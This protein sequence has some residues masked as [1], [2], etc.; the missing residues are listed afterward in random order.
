[1][2]KQVVNRNNVVAG[3]F[4]VGSVLLAVAISFLLS[5]ISGKF[6]KKSEYV[7][8][9]STDV[10]VTGLEAGAEI[11][12]GGLH[13]GR[14]EGITAHK[15]ADPV[16]GIEVI[17]A[18]DV[19]VALV[20]DLVLHE[21]A[22]ADLMLPMLGGLSTINI[23]SAGTGSYVGGPED[24]NGLMD[25]GE[26]MR[27]RF[28]PSILTQ[29]GF[30][31]EEAEKIKASIDDVK[32]I[33]G[34]ARESTA[35]VRRMTDALEPEFIS[36]VDDGKSTI[37]NVRAF[38]EQLN[39]E[40]GWS[41]RVDGIL[42]KAE[43]ASAKLEPT[44]DE[45]RATLVDARAVIAESKPKV[46]E[47]LDNVTETTEQFKLESLAKMDALIEKGSLALGSYKDLADDARLIVSESRPK[48]DSTLD[49][50]RDIGVNSKMMIEELR[51]QPWRLLK[52]PTKEELLREPI[53]EAARAYASAVSDLRI[54]SE[55]LDAAVGRVAEAGSSVNASDLARISKVVEEAYGR[56]EVA[57][58]GL[59]ERLMSSVPTNE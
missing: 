21:N 16:S 5:D 45:A 14:V 8:R 32:A 56:Y 29:L 48:I 44:I 26:V 23:P 15:A 3:M 49:S 7:F 43:G 51:A 27:G 13:V 38:S 1:M 28:A 30:S 40:D 46:L 19:R 50:A 36:G 54:A 52:K 55:A 10:G 18:H 4:F 6:G 59:L 39:G 42:V 17:V 31:T 57:E 24:E 35:S 12:F 25:P 22:Y 20:S 37:E 33:T 11:T 41:G 58:N 47:I 34:D 53:Y 9:F 2:S